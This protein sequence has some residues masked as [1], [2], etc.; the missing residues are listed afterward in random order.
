M[1]V[2]EK[3][4]AGHPPPIVS[5]PPGTLRVPF[6]VL[7]DAREKA[8]YLFAGL[9]ADAAQKSCPLYVPCQWR[10][11]ATGDYSIDGLEHLVAI[12]RKSLADLYSTLGQERE[13]FAR[14]HERMR[15]IVD[16][17]GYC[18]VVIEANWYQIALQPPAESRL[19]P[20]TVF[21]TALSWM[22]KYQVQW[23]AFGDRR[24]AEIATFRM[25]EKFWTHYQDQQR[26]LIP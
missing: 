17:G 18:A 20:K 22:Q 7:V 15:A 23:H 5:Q 8:P 24:F 19:N 14:E 10:T 25:L 3:P 12:E 26:E 13:R 11:L 16:A 21:R 1:E 4:P 6:H 9:L 2:L